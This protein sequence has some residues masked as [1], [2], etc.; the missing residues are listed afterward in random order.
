MDA[1]CCS[2]CGSCCQ[3]PF[4]HEGTFSVVSCVECGHLYTSPLPE[5]ESFLTHYAASGDWIKA[6]SITEESGADSRFHQ[7]SEALCRIVPK[8]G[9][10]I[11]VGCSKGRLLYLLQQQGF[12]CYGVDLVAMQRSHL[13]YSALIGYPT[14]LMPRL[15]PFKQTP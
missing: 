13:N 6:T 14:L 9:K 11:E 7:Y 5:E 10:I 1:V 4:L 8:G 12:D 15:Y 2:V 3:Q